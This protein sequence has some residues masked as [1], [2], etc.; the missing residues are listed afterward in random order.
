MAP[1]SAALSA[2]LLVLAVLT[3]LAALALRGLSTASGQPRDDDED[4][5]PDGPASR[6]WRQRLEVSE[7]DV[8]RIRGFPQRR[9]TGKASLE[10][11]KHRKHRLTA[12]RF[13][14]A[15]I[16]ICIL[17]IYIYIYRERER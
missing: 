14:K 6:K 4:D 9:S 10:W 17:C 2:A 12:S 1:L 15:T 3:A 5:S 13:N 7:A 11:L 8:A 16:C